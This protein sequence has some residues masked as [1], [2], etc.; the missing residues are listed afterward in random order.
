MTPGRPP[1]ATLLR[2][3]AP[4]LWTWIAAS[5]LTWW[6]RLG[7]GLGQPSQGL[8]LSA[9]ALPAALVALV[10]PRRRRWGMA[11]V[12]AGL[13]AL[14]LAN[15]TYHRFFGVFLPLRAV[16]DL[17]QAWQ[18]RDYVPGLLV[19][20][21]MGVGAVVLA[22]VAAALVSRG[23]VG[24]PP[25]PMRRRWHTGLALAL[26]VAGGGPALG[27]AWLVAPGDADTETG[28]FVYGHLL[29]AR[30]VVG[31]W[32]MEGEPRAA[33]WA[34][35]MD[36]VGERAASVPSSSDAWWGRAAGSS[37]LL[38]QVEAL[39]AWLVDTEVGGEPVMP[40]LQELSR[41]GLAFTNVFD[42]T[43]QGRSSDADYLVMGSQHPLERDAVSM[44]RPDLDPVALSTV[45]R[46]EG[47]TTF[48]AHAHIPGFW[49][50]AR[51]HRAYGIQESLFEAELGPGETLG[52]GLTDQVFLQRSA[53]HLLRLPR[54]WLAWLITLTM[55]GPHPAVPPSFPSLSLGPLEGSPLGNY[56][57]KARHT[58]DALRALLDTLAAHGALEG[59]TVVVYGDHTESHPFD[60][61]WVAREAGLAGLPD[62]ARRLLLDRVPL[63]VVPSGPETPAS[64]DAPGGLLDVGP[65]LLHLL[66][67]PSPGFWMG[68]SL[69]LPGD[70][71]VAQA[72]G[73]AVGGGLMW[74]GLACYAFPAAE[75]RL[76]DECADIRAR[77][78]E[79]L[80]VSWIITRHGLAR[81]LD[82]GA[83]PR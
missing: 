27:W 35:V 62:D 65:T 44:V 22:T 28:G 73:E 7:E 68:R 80:E 29:D 33:A 37:V 25:A 3:N 20:G 15:A 59:T 70:G 64:F 48:S 67:I 81:E 2:V 79:E 53:P 52:L 46:R 45:L 71:L 16:R 13:G 57:R 36:H 56:M 63:I 32:R 26:C 12:V 5:A 14:A 83:V 58:D 9:A 24:P 23:R 78:R 41:R 66:G 21:D 47:Y 6:I 40:F 61:E 1:F 11:V 42:E 50:A 10:P 69:T 60:G 31:E 43:H 4:V 76:P 49:N 55:H 75:P 72:S 19:P 82:L 74:T 34:R 18:V 17:G 39:N 38:V 51:R 54:P 77:A 8:A 30:R